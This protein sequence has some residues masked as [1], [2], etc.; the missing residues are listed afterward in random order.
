MSEQ[1]LPGVAE[2][3]VIRP[4]DTLILRLDSG[5]T[6]GQLEARRDRLVPSLKARV[7]GVEVIML[8]GV[9]QMAVYRPDRPAEGDPA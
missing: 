9:E 4:G 7:P 3:L 5:L 2:A 8:G 1:S 6:P